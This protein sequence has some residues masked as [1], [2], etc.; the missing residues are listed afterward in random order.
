MLKKCFFR[1]RMENVK[2][3]WLRMNLAVLSDE[4]NIVVTI[5]NK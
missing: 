2:S 4:T 5:I 3:I 1:L